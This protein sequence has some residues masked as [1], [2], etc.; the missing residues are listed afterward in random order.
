MD[1][2]LF[3]QGVIK[4]LLGVL[5]VGLLLFVP[6]GSFEYTNAW[7]FMG[8]LFIP[9]FIVGIILMFKNP[10]LLKRRLDAREKEFEQKKVLL[11]SGLMFIIVF[12]TSGLNYRYE[13]FVLP[14]IVVIVSSIL[15]V[16]AYLLYAMVLKENTFLSRTIEVT[17]KQTLVDTGLYGIVR[18]PMY[19]ITLVL[20]L[21]IPLILGS[22]ISF[23]ITLVYPFIINIRIKNEEQVLE[24]EL[25][26]YK[27]YKKKVKYKMI[28]F[29][30]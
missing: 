20:F 13:W 5:L 8:L 26:G 9:M 1:I 22:I 3:F 16:L 14:N 17:N 10:E 15:F 21:M 23:V 30:W 24:K 19:A 29:I 27:E 7:I 18:H 6:A 28:P 2:K 11:Y 25:K 4:Y 12:I